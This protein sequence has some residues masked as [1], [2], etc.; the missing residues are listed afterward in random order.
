MRGPLILVVLTLALTLALARFTLLSKRKL[1]WFVDNGVVDGWMDPRF[2]TM[3]GML[4]RGMSVAN[5]REFMI[6][7]VRSARL[8]SPM[9]S[10]SRCLAWAEAPRVVCRRQW[11]RCACAGASEE[12]IYIG[13]VGVCL[14]GSIAY[15]GRLQACGG[16]GVGQVLVNQHPLLGPNRGALQRE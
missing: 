16:H 1:T 10:T 2:P 14:V 11:C 13:A 8:A 5:L 12:F 3:Q 9:C 7:Q 4:R 6:S 15:A